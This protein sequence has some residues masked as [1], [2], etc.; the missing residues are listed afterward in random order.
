MALLLAA[1]LL[2]AEVNPALAVTTRSSNFEASE[3]EFGAGSALETCSGLYCARATIGDLSPTGSS[4]KSTAAFSPIE[5]GSEDALL[6][7]I[8]DPGESNLGVLDIDKTASKSSVV[9]VRNYLSQGY[10]VQ[11][12]GKPP[13][14]DGH[15]LNTPTTP[16]ESTTGTEQFG[17]NVVKNTTPAIG[18]NPVYVPSSEVSFGEAAPGYD[19]PNLFKYKDGD[20]IAFSEKE[21]GRTDFTVSMIINVSGATPAGHYATDFSVL[22][23]PVY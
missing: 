20:V 19:Q 8:I 21:S 15:T 16:T 7:V 23:V 13:V 18:E 11:L 22:V 5:A 14:Y 10:T 6:E 2:V 9:R 12:I 17:V 1:F 3:A 4:S